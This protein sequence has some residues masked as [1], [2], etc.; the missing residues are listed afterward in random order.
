[1]TLLAPPGWEVDADPGFGGLFNVGFP[2]S[3]LELTIMDG[4][5]DAPGMAASVMF[6]VLGE[7]LPQSL[8]EGATLG[9]ADTI[10]TD[11]G[12]PLTRIRYRGE[13]SDGEIG[14]AFDILCTGSKVYLVFA[15]APADQ[16][17]EFGELVDWIERT[18]TVDEEQVDLLTAE[19]DGYYFVDEDGVLEVWVPDGWHV[20]DLIP[21]GMPVAMANSDYTIALML[22][23]EDQLAE[24]GGAD[25]LQGMTLLT[26][27]LTEEAV[28]LLAHIVFAAAVTDYEDAR[29]D[30]DT[31]VSV[32]HDDG[33][34]VSVD[35]EME[36]SAGAV[37]PVVLYVDMRDGRLAAAVA[38]GDADVLLAE[39]KNVQEV[40][41]SLA[42]LD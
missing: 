2:D 28:D 35:G 22:T 14:G 36:L 9:Y 23:S 13:T 10:Q 21:A 27:G 18:L 1:M 34:T 41:R 16:W 32:A 29:L 19:G 25:L 20:S 11:Q 6:R 26:A 8:M 31:L 7:V 39:V 15:A 38:V 4:G 42:V 17:P 33:L 40:V 24:E 12:L 5:D 3:E 30:P 37:V